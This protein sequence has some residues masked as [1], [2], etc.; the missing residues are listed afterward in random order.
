M[1]RGMFEESEKSR[2]LEA[3]DAAI[4]WTHNAAVQVVL[5][6]KQ[7]VD[8]TGD[9]RAQATYRYDEPEFAAACGSIKI[10]SK[11]IA[12]PGEIVDF[13]IRF[14]NLGDQTIKRSC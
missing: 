8:V 6:G 2:L 12:K 1:Q 9:Q 3:I 7:A 13:T 5:D 10:A 11:K 4:V 14:D